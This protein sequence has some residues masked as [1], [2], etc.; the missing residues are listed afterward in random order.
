M[1]ESIEDRL[2][3]GPRRGRR[4]GPPPPRCRP[5]RRRCSRHGRRI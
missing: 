1:A 2:G 3:R 5:C 4:E